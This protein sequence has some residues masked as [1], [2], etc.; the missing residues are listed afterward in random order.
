MA[1]VRA[2]LDYIGAGDIYQMNL[3]QRFVASLA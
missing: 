1:A 3:S 2:A